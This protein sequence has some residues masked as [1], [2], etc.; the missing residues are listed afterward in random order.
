MLTLCIRTD[1]PEAELYLYSGRELL[2]ELKWEAHRR[3]AETIHY[4]IDE[5][6]HQKEVSLKDLHKIVVYQGPGSFTGLRI[7]IAVANTLAYTLKI[8]IIGG[9][10]EPWIIHSLSKD[11]DE[12]QFVSPHYGQTPH[13]TAQKK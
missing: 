7:G 4:K 3:L 13:I 12:N 2:V 1:K 11:R 9:Q 8:P 10:G 6:L 5:S